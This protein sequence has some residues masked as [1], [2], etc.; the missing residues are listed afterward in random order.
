METE[1]V[2]ATHTLPTPIG[3]LEFLATTERGV[4][5]NAYIKSCA[6]EPKLPNGMAVQRCVAVL[7]QCEPS[8]NIEGLVFRCGWKE[9]QEKGYGCTGEALDAW[10]WEHDRTLVVIG[11]EDNEWLSHRLRFID[12]AK[13]AN[14]YPVTMR[15]NVIEIRLSVVPPGEPVSLH[16]IVAWNSLPEKAE[17]SC[18]FAVDVPHERVRSACE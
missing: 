12:V 13:T 8:E 17:S 14:A 18:W 5:R 4:T 11:T 7:F 6:I 1:T 15:D 3:S 2:T 16:Y 10:E 9:L